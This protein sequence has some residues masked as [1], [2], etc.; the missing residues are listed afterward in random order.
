MMHTAIAA[1]TSGASTRR[2]R[3]VWFP[4]SLGEPRRG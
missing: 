1:N 3:S 4:L 2:V